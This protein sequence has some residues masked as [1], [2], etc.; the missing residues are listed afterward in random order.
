L[1]L[2]GTGSVPMVPPLL[3][4]YIRCCIRVHDNIA[5]TRRMP[6]VVDRN[7]ECTTCVDGHRSPTSTRNLCYAHCWTTNSVAR[8]RNHLPLVPLHHPQTRLDRYLGSNA[9][10]GAVV[11]RSDPVPGD[12]LSGSSRI[13][14]KALIP[15]PLNPL[16]FR[17]SWRMSESLLCGAAKNAALS[18]GC[19]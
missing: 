11:N 3:L 16:V 6:L 7:P 18:D 2:V 10:V 1:R 4:N 17:I 14:R 9:L 8:Y 19:Q 13:R 15:V 12:R 5:S